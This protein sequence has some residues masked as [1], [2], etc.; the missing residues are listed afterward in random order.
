MLRSLFLGK[1]G[2]AWGLLCWAAQGSRFPLGLFAFLCV[3]LVWVLLAGLAGNPAGNGMA[4]NFKPCVFEESLE[5]GLNGAFNPPMP[6]R[7][8]SQ[9][10][11]TG[12][13]LNT[14]PFEG[15]CRLIV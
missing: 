14:K 1:V 10:E 2:S 15:V 8:N 4:P 3:C 7:P 9:G 6:L 5:S 11:Y 12:N 13:Y